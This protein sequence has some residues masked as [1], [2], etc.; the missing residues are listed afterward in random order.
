MSSASSRRSSSRLNG[1]GS[2]S[3][4]DTTFVTFDCHQANQKMSGG[5]V[6]AL[7]ERALAGRGRDIQLAA[8]QSIKAFL[9]KLGHILLG[10]GHAS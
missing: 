1:P 9:E 7:G 8:V 2:V 5:Q 10:L 4:S 3:V 6:G